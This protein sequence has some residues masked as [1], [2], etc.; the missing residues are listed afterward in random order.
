MRYDT[1]TQDVV[2]SVC[3]LKVRD[4]DQCGVCGHWFPQPGPSLEDDTAARLSQQGE[5]MARETAVNRPNHQEGR[6]DGEQD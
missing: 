2:C 3:G 4:P 6:H 5:R 1:L